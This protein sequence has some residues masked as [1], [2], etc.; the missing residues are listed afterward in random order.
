[1][2]PADTPQGGDGHGRAVLDIKMLGDPILRTVARQL[3]RE[4]LADA[5]TQAFIDDL[6]DTMH[7][8]RGAGIAAPQVGRDLSIAVVHIEDNPRYPYKP[9]VP[10]TVFVNPRITPLTRATASVYEGC[11]SVPGI[12]GRVDR[13]MRVRVDAWDRRGREL[14]FEARGQTAG[15]F[16]HQFDHQQGVLFVDR[17][18]DPTTLSTWDN[19]EAHHRD[20]FVKEAL[21]IQAKFGQ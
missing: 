18:T 15:T 4:Q 6:V 17:V 12:R 21:A 8:A 20:A 19:F 7:A 9:N 1:M 14:S 2:D 5:S 3:T 16:Q 10:L 11:L 13:F